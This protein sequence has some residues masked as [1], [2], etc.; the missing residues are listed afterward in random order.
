MK[1]RERELDAL[2]D[3]DYDKLDAQRKD[4]VRDDLFSEQVKVSVSLKNVCHIRVQTQSL[5]IQRQQLHNELSGEPWFAI[6]R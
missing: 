1:S 3:Q 6:T 2:P 4:R 5:L